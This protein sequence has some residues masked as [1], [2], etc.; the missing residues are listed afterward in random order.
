MSAVAAMPLPRIVQTEL[1]DEL[2][3]DDPR[4]QRSRR[5][6][7][8]VHRVMGTCAILRKALRGLR[9]DRFSGG[10][11]DALLAHLAELPLLITD[12]AGLR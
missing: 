11:A 12:T 2:A 1:L 6:N 9:L 5:D 4:A 3:A 8:R 7:R 10:F